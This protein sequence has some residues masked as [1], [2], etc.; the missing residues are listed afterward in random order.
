V[1]HSKIDPKTWTQWSLI[2]RDRSK[3]TSKDGTWAEA[4]QAYVRALMIYYGPEATDNPVITETPDAAFYIF[5]PEMGYPVHTWECMTRMRKLRRI[6][7]GEWVAP[8]LF[9]EIKEQANKGFHHRGAATRNAW[10]LYYADG[11][12][13]TADD[14]EWNEAP[15]DG[16]VLAIDGVHGMRCGNDYYFWENGAMFCTHDLTHALQS[17]PEIKLGM[18]SYVNWPPV[19]NPFL[20]VQCDS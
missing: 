3:F 14:C 4:P 2:Y 12:V 1:T 10:A 13:V 16:V 5:V 17:M 20:T 18:T 15:L 6:K 11:T 19:C 9:K 7:F 8:S